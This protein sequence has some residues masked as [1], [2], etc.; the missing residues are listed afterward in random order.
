MLV[1]G[2]VERP[3]RQHHNGR[4]LARPRRRRGLQR[5]QQ[6]VGIDLDRPH[7]MFGE[8]V[9]EQ[10][11]HHLAVLQHIGDPG[12]RADI[13]LQHIEAVL[14][15][16][17]QIDPGDMAPDVARRPA[18]LHLGPIVRIGQDQVGGH[19]PGAD[20]VLRPVDVL[21]EGVDGGDPLLQPLLQ[22]APFVGADDARDDIERDQPL[23][24]FL[25]AIDGEGHAHPAEE[26]L[27]LARARLQ[28]IRRGVFQPGRQGLVAVADRPRS[29]AVHFVESS[30]HSP[31]PR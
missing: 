12:R 26:Q 16:A 1:I 17:N 21:Q 30:R 24:G 31:P 15:R 28:Q 19:D 7:R 10:P 22:P 14:A 9:G 18:P 25:V 13:V 3:G 23:V 29:A 2:R 27:G 5:A 11:H 20:T 6:H 4:I 8:Q